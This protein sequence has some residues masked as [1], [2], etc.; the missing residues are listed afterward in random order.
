[1]KNR[2]TLRLSSVAGADLDLSPALSFF[3]RQNIKVQESPHYHC[4]YF[5][6][7]YPYQSILLFISSFTK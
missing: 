4:W 5:E 2:T 3:H 1:M 6:I 7:K